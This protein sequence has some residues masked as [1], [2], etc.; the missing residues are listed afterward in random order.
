MESAPAM[1]PSQPT[2]AVQSL[3]DRLAAQMASHVEAM[4]KVQFEK[5]QHMVEAKQQQVQEQLKQMVD[6]RMAEL[7]SQQRAPRSRSPHGG[8]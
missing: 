6:T 4:L 8:R 7:S 1:A 3:Q 2:P 5:L